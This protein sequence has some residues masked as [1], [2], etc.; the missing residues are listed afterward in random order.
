[1]SKNFTRTAA[2]AAFVSITL[3]KSNPFRILPRYVHE[4]FN[5]I[6]R[7]PCVEHILVTKI[8]TCQLHPC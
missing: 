5:I 6:F 2:L 8:S 4:F 3:F 1:M 7:V